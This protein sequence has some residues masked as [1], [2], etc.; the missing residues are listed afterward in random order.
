MSEEIGTLSTYALVTKAPAPSVIE[1]ARL[2]RAG[3]FVVADPMGTI[4]LF[5]AP[6]GSRSTS[7]R[8][9]KPARE[10]VGRTRVSAWLLLGNEYLSE[11]VML[12]PT[13]KPLTL[14]WVADWEPPE[15]PATYLA[16]RKAWDSFCAEIAARY[17]APD[18][19]PAL[20]LVRN[21][22]VPGHA[23]PPVSDLLRQVCVA[24]DLPD[25]A[26]GRSLLDSPE[27]GLHQAQ[28]FDVA[29]SGLFRRVLAR[30]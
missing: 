15:D 7:R 27:P 1:A 23:R 24:F 3:G 10:L 22:P 25:V 20:A 8:L 16:D 12:A 29:S 30:S 28:R 11:A 5:D 26:V 14:E 2:G 19:G 6:S 17:G 13:A 18:R 4:V 21:D 9:A